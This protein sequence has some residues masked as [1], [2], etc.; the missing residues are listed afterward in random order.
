MLA[1]KL[2]ILST[3]RPYFPQHEKELAQAARWFRWK[4]RVARLGPGPYLFLQ[5]LYARPGSRPG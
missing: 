3:L 5:R 1:D 4:L 2:A